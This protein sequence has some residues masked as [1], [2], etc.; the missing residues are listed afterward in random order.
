VTRE[1]EDKTKQVEALA[2]RVDEVATAVFAGDIEPALQDR[3]ATGL[4]DYHRYLQ[5]LGLA[6]DGVLP[7][8]RVGSLVSENAY[9]NRMENELVVGEAIKEDLDRVLRLYTFHVLGRDD[10]GGWAARAP[11]ASGLAY[12]FPCSYRKDPIF[13]KI[14]ARALE[15]VRGSSVAWVDLRDELSFEMMRETD[16]DP[17]D[18]GRVWAAVLWEV[19]QSVGAS[20]TDQAAVAAWR[21]TKAFEEAPVSVAFARS[22]VA[23]FDPSWATTVEDVFGRR[24]LDL[25]ENGA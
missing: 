18:S 8:V 2:D 21:G 11:V 9:Y 24:G 23:A 13:G 16:L 20:A 6:A 14:S 10:E 7:K 15:R 4:D 22:L 5:K 19:R 25:D 1:L 12:Y 3:L 17:A